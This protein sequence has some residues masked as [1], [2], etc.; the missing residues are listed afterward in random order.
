MPSWGMRRIQRWLGQALVHRGLPPEWF[1]KVKYN[2]S[3]IEEQS[4]EGSVA[5][6]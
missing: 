4:T 5:G 1:Y 3:S 6:G 2:E